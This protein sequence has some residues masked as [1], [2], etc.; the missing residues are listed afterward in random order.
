[1]AYLYPVMYGVGGEGLSFTEIVNLDAIYK[2]RYYEP[3]EGKES[4]IVVYFTGITDV[5][6]HDV[7][8]GMLAKSSDTLEHS[9]HEV[10]WGEVADRLWERIRED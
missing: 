2:C 5:V 9:N 3:Y 4:R 8:W 6:K 10:F 7:P 1:M